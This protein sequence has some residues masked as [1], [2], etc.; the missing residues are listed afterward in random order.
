VQGDGAINNNRRVYFGHDMT[1]DGPLSSE[2]VMTSTGITVSFRVRIPDSGPL[3]DVYL[4]TDGDDPDTD[5][6]VLPWF[7]D[8]PNGRGTPMTNGRGSINIAQNDPQNIDT[9]VGFS[10]VTSTDVTAFCDVS[11]GALCTGSGSG[12]LIMNNLNGNAPSNFI[13]SESGGTLNMLE[14]SDSE[15]NDWNEFW[16]TMENNAGLPGNIEVN[17]YRNGALTPDTFQ[18]TLAAFNNSV[19]AKEDNPFLDFGISSNGGFGSFD[20]DF[21]AYQIGVIAPV[22]APPE[23]ADFDDDGDIDGNDFLIWQAGFDG[24]GV[25]P[26]DGNANGDAAVN[27]LDLAVWKSQ[28]GGAAPL[29]GVLGNVPEPTGVTLGLLGALTWAAA[30]RRRSVV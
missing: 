11:S 2:L 1:Q 29:S 28:Y 5:P 4:E 18:V 20:M 15:L 25:T 16:I 22:A 24:A 13:D 27:A 12:G 23:N 3:D 9:Q 8:S 30:V 21:L 7:Q 14:L 10:L 19:Y 17:V 26:G 6:D